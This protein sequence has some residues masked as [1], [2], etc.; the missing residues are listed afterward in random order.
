[1][2]RL[3]KFGFFPVK[4]RPFLGY[5]VIQPGIL[6]KLIFIP[7]SKDVPDAHPERM[8]V[9]VTR[10]T[11]RKFEGI[12]DNDPINIPG[13]SSGDR[14]VFSRSNIYEVWED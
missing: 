14:V 8:W 1:M 9:K 12:L 13:L 7:L 11:G 3:K 2:Y 6:V 5:E 4:S 10:Q